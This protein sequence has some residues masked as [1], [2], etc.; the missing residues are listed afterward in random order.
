[1]PL[2]KRMFDT[3]GED[4]ITLN[5]VVVKL[6]GSDP[7]M[8]EPDIKESAIKSDIRRKLINGLGGNEK[9]FK[10]Q[11]AR[12]GIEYEDG[13]NYWYSVEKNGSLDSW[14]IERGKN[15]KR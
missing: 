14:F 15:F 6:L 7:R 3:A 10:G 4:K 2:I 12:T 11:Y 9:D 1:M 8:A 13:Y 5:S